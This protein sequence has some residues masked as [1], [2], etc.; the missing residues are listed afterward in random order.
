MDSNDFEARMRS[1]EYFHGLRLLPE[2]WTVIRVDGRSFSNER[3]LWALHSE[4]DSRRMKG[5]TNYR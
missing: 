2:A 5:E 3:R 4:N 1:F